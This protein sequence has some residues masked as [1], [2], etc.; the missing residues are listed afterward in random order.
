MINAFQGANRS[1]NRES[2]KTHEY[3]MQS[4]WGLKE[5][6]DI[7]TIRALRVKNNFLFV[8]NLRTLYAVV[9]W[10]PLHKY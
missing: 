1:L 6:V 2:Y 4:D 10:D 9:K 7:F 3:K 8:R 5:L